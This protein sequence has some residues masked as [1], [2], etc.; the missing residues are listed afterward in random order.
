M[1]KRFEESSMRQ[2]VSAGEEA[3]GKH[4]SNAEA[5]RLARGASELDLVNSGLEETVVDA[6]HEIRELSGRHQGIDLR[7]ASTISAIDKIAASYKHRG[8]FP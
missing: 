1:A 2:V 6:Y 8:I 5:A 4:F 3:T 7:T